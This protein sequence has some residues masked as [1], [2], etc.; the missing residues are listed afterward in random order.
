VQRLPTGD[1]SREHSTT[2]STTAPAAEHHLGA[3][4]PRSS[5]PTLPGSSSSDPTSQLLR[6]SFSAVAVIGERHS[7]TNVVRSLLQLN[8]DKR[9]HAIWSNFTTHKHYL[10][11]VPAHPSPHTLVI[12]SVRNAYDWAAAMHRL[13]YCCERRTRLGIDAFL[14]EPFQSTNS[15]GPD[16]A[17]CPNIDRNIFAGGRQFRNLIDMRQWKLLNHLNTSKCGP[18][19]TYLYHLPHLLLDVHPSRIPCQVAMSLACAAPKQ[20]ALSCVCALHAPLHTMMPPVSCAA[21]SLSGALI[22]CPADF[23]GCTLPLPSRLFVLD[24]DIGSS[25]QHKHKTQTPRRTYTISNL[26]GTG[27]QPV[28]NAAIQSNLIHTGVVGD[29][30]PSWI[31]VVANYVAGGGWE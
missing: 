19:T 12:M 20:T 21:A 13:C 31:S 30:A 24:P 22:R 28:D 1:T 16:A 5:D 4:S 18:P 7:G 3:S 17:A 10:Q 25:Y 6:P 15:G 23:G 2:N 29:Y 8:L 26:Y 14:E 11:P 27:M 9:F